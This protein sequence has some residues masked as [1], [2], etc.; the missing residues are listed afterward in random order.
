MVRP[1]RIQAEDS[2]YHVMTR[3]QNRR[4]I[5]LDDSD[6]IYFMDLLAETCRTFECQVVAHC[7]MYNHMHIALHTQHANLSQ[8]IKT[9]LGTY[10]QRF[11]FL[12]K[13][14]GPLFKGRFKSTLVNDESYL[15][16]LVP[17][18]HQNPVKAGICISEQNFEWSSFKLYERFFRGEG[19]PNW[20][21]LAPGLESKQVFELIHGS[22]GEFSMGLGPFR[23]TTELPTLCVEES[24]WADQL[25][26]RGRNRV[27]QISD[28]IAVKRHQIIES[29]VAKLAAGDGYALK[30]WAQRKL[31][32][33][34]SEMIAEQMG[35]ESIEPIRRA[36][37]K[38]SRSRHLQQLKREL[39]DR[40]LSVEVAKRYGAR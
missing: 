26:N 29:F 4:A 37:V 11:N 35:Y 25:Q 13:T 10:V 14:D 3:G 34:E 17:Y 6:K 5:F 23:S 18:I 30:I 19:V 21:R 31:L 16:A 33:W 36:L 8:A 20:F 22:S 2:Y 1:L 7:L 38:T 27:V 40:F 9:L 28:R 15:R 39:S 24:A 12:H 32:G